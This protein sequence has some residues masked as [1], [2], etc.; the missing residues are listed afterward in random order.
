ME[1]IGKKESLQSQESER[2][3]KLTVNRIPTLMPN[4]K[5][6]T[7]FDAI[8]HQ[9]S[10]E[11]KISKQQAQEIGRR[12]HQSNSN[13]GR[14]L[15]RK[16]KNLQVLTKL[17]FEN[18]VKECTFRPDTS[19]TMNKQS[20]YNKMKSRSQS[21][22][23]DCVSII[24]SRNL[25]SSSNQ[26]MRSYENPK[27]LHMNES[28]DKPYLRNLVRKAG[29]GNLMFNSLQSSNSMNSLT[30]SGMQNSQMTEKRTFREFYAQQMDHIKKKVDYVQNNL[31]K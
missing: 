27:F 22:E 19:L 6:L 8:Y 5:H 9:K 28:Y 30:P 31:I 11:R 1:L 21:R 3:Y 10:P 29:K 15:E 16:K 20:L 26:L 12:L 7:K 4:S 14:S 13:R 2:N 18:E 23:K 24:N 17:K 25:N